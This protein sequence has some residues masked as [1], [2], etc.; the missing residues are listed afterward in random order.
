MTTNQTIDGVP[1]LP[2]PFCM[3]K[4]RAPKCKPAGHADFS[5]EIICNCGVSYS[6]GDE[7]GTIRGWNRRAKL[8]AQPQGEG[9]PVAWMTRCIKGE[10]LGV[11]EQA[12]GPDSVHNNEYWTPAFAVY[13]E[14]HAPVVVE[15]KLHMGDAMEVFDALKVERLSCKVEHEELGP[16][17]ATAIETWSTAIGVTLE[18]HNSMGG[19]TLIMRTAPVAM[20]L[21]ER[22]DGDDP[23]DPVKRAW[24][25]CLDEVTRLNKAKD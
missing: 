19:C 6:S 5:W 1:L 16:M 23:Y 9:E 25:A 2:C 3:G 17:G 15:Y 18:M 24:N 12:D 11:V 8:A 20:A 7:H 22:E 13:A 14:R 21:P 10:G 4:V